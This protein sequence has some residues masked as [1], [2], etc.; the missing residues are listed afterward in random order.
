MSNMSYCQF[1][2]TLWDLRQCFD[3]LNEGDTLSPDEQRHARRLVM[4]CQLIGREF[5]PDHMTNNAENSDAE[6]MREINDI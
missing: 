1:E 2:N 5:D 3:T 6:K 4:L